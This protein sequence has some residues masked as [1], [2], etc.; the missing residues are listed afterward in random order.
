[1]LPAFSV[2][3]RENDLSE[4]SEF[5]FTAQRHP[6]IL[7][8]SCC[9]SPTRSVEGSSRVSSDISTESLD[10]NFAGSTV[11]FR[12]GLGDEEERAADELSA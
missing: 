2:A 8:G 7:N 11:E 4:T 10:G 5:G 9:L 12:E 6:R 1:M 3:P